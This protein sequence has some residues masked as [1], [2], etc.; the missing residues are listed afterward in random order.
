MRVQEEKEGVRIL[1]ECP[2]DLWYLKNIIKKGDLIESL[3]T[4]RVSSREETL[5]PEDEKRVKVVLTVEVEEV[6]FHPFTERLRVRGIIRAGMDIG[7]YHTFNLEPGVEILLKRELRD[8]EREFLEE[9]V[10]GGI[11][12]RAFLISV[13]DEDIVVYLVNDYG[14]KEVA[15][16]PYPRRGKMYQ[17]KEVSFS[18]VEDLLSLI[19]ENDP[20]GE[21]PLILI[22]PGFFKEKIV[23]EMTKEREELKGR[24]HTLA[25]SSGGYSGVKEA[26]KSQ[27]LVSMLSTLRIMRDLNILK[28]FFEGIPR[29]LSTYGRDEVIKAVNW[30][31]A[32]EVLISESHL[33]E[34][35]AEDLFKLAKST[36]TRV[37][38]VSEEHEEGRMFKKMGG[39]G[40][41]L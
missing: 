4:R 25:T 13:D 41:I 19:R 16:L 24:I 7:R 31:A 38:V 35:W 12:K 5:R 21:L 27:K 9:A 8:E 15:A 10:K 40:A 17:Q 33:H 30:G 20:G 39:V 34:S 18:V 26:L 14:I 2:E 28:E 23:E 29:G 6:E 1:L 32:K 22:G 3:T 37:V 36:G 11:G